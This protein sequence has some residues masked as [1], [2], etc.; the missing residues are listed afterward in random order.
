[1]ER[2]SAQDAG[3]SETVHNITTAIS[4]H[5]A[6]T[7]Q[8]VSVATAGLQRRTNL[9]WWKE[10]LFSPS[11]CRSYRDLPVFSAAA[12]MAFDLHQQIPGS[13][14][15]SVAA[16]LRETVTTL[17]G[18][19]G[20]QKV[21]I[22]E[23]VEDAGESCVLTDLR[24]E[25]ARLVPAPRGRGLLLGLIGHPELLSQIDDNGFRDLAGVESDTQLSLPDWSVW[26]LREFQAARTVVEASPVKRRTSSRRRTSRK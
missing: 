4:G 23:L 9:L 5:L 24:T 13:S 21:T 19:D 10:A 2:V 18:L 8:T 20:N 6:D 1:M 26:L 14:P 16:F 11:V 7:I 25:A 15:I 17:P 3:L 22:R 12:L